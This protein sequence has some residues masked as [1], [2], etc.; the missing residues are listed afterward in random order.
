MKAREKMGFSIGAFHV[1]QAESHVRISKCHKALSAHH[2]LIADAET[3]KSAQEIRNDAHRS[4]S[5]CHKE[6]SDHHADVAEQH[7]KAAKALG[8]EEAIDTHDDS[9]GTEVVRAAAS[10]ETFGMPAARD[11]SKIRP[12]GVRGALP[13]VPRLV[14]RPGQ[15]PLEKTSIEDATAVIDQF[16]K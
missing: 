11:F 12:D 4:I 6:L 5:D 3:H 13:D 15:A 8:G 9:R 2:A 16:Q 14:P 10:S 1:G 7:L